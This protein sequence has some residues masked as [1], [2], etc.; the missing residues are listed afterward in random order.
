M[1][2]SGGGDNLVIRPA[3]ATNR[4]DGRIVPYQ[5]RDDTRGIGGVT[6]RN[7]KP[8]VSECQPRR[9]PDDGSQGVTA[10]ERPFR[11]DSADPTRRA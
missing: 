2:S 4:G 5:R 7:G 1:A 11:H 6:L 3:A 10:A 8:F 9:I